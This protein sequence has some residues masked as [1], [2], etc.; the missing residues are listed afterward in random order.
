[1]IIS[2]ADFIN[3]VLKDELSPLAR[4]SA[5]TMAEGFDAVDV[6]RAS[7]R[8]IVEEWTNEAFIDAAQGRPDGGYSILL[9]SIARTVSPALSK[10][11]LQTV[12]SQDH[13]GARLGRDRRRRARHAVRRHRAARRDHRSAGRAAG[14]ARRA[15]AHRIRSAAG[16]EGRRAAWTGVGTGAQGHDAFPLSLLGTDQRRR[17]ARRDVLPRRRSTVPNVLD[18]AAD[19]L[20]DAHRLGRR[21]ARSGAGARRATRTRSRRLALQSLDGMF[22]KHWD[23]A[24]EFEASWCHDWQNDPFSRGAYSYVGVG[25]GNARAELSKPVD[26]T[27]FFAGEATD[28][29]GDA[30]TVTGALESGERAAR[31]VI[32]AS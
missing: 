8:S 25:G 21:P 6:T 12:D 31:E 24:D 14:E 32:A 3:V 10:T 22:G 29:T 5:C 30:A 16:F 7:A 15:G 19:P 2:F 28:E 17:A 9:E 26:G 18:H 23:V 1:M 27:L 11:Q 4:R 13:V 20:I